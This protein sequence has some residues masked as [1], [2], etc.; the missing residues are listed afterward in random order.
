MTTGRS[1]SAYVPVESIRSDRLALTARMA[2]YLELAKPRIAAKDND[3]MQPF[4][5]RL[6][7]DGRIVA[8][9]RAVG[10]CRQWAGR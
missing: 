5:D 10:V 9:R 8:K 1:A 2:D 6:Q 4:K 7:R 3:A